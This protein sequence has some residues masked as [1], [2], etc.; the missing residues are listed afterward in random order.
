MTAAEKEITRRMTAIAETAIAVA[1]A[2]PP[3]AEEAAWIAEIRQNYEGDWTDETRADFRRLYWEAKTG[4][5][6]WT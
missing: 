6:D 2:R 5:A 3:D 4:I 1:L